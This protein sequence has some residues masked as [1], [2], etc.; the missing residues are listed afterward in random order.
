[1]LSFL[2]NSETTLSSLLGAI[3]NLNKAYEY[4]FVVMF[5]YKAVDIFVLYFFFMAIILNCAGVPKKTV[6]S[7]V[8]WK[9]CEGNH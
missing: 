2:I 3:N 5:I 6:N 8:G 4:V 7:A 1:M 9:F